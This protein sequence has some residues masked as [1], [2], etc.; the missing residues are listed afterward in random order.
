MLYV[1]ARFAS[2]R[3]ICVVVC[4]TE[5]IEAAVKK[6]VNELVTH[7]KGSRTRGW[8]LIGARYIEISIGRYRGIGSKNELCAGI[9][10][11]QK[12]KVR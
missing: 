9:F 11:H 7:L 2:R 4:Q 3:T 1:W 10:S 6:V 12:M 8:L 5:N